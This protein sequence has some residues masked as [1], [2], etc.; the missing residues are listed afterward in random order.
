MK[1]ATLGLLLLS[2]VIARAQGFPFPTEDALWVNTLYTM[3][4]PPPLPTFEMALAHNYCANGSDSVINTTTYTKLE[5]CTGGYKGAFREDA[6]RVYYV[7]ADSTEEYLLY[8]F[9]LTDG[10]TANN[11]YY[12]QGMGMSGMAF[13]QD[14]TV[15]N[16]MISTELGGRKVLYLQEG[17]MWIEGIGAAWGLF[18]E[19][20]INVSNYA[21]NL[22]CMSHLDTIRYP[23]MNVGPGVCDLITGIRQ[24]QG[25]AGMELLPNPAVNGRTLL[26]GTATEWNG[27]LRVTTADGRE[28]AVRTTRTADGVYIDMENAPSGLYLVQLQHNN[29]PLVM[30]LIRE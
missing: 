25:L 10:Q 3:V 19:P 23:E 21:L 29:A 16:T 15:S 2:S 5:F 14:V 1:H 13:V 9:T 28:I 7:P 11:V 24:P 8:D 30:R 4:Q 27:R 22:E 26:R 12:E 18:S 20:W 17:G 6:G